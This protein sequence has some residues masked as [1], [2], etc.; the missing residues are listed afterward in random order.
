M[1]ILGYWSYD[2][3]RYII[4]TIVVLSVL[5]AIIG[6]NVEKDD[7]DNKQVSKTIQRTVLV[8][9]VFVGVALTVFVL[10]RMH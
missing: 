8:I 4:Y 6:F 1:N 7:E 10:V 3:I 9:A 2:N 5:N